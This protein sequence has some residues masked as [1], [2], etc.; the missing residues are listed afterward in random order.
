MINA[1]EDKR[2]THKRLS[3]KDLAS[4]LG[5]PP[6]FWSKLTTTELCNPHEFRKIA[7]VGEGLCM[8]F[9]ID[10]NRVNISNV[11]SVIEY[12]RELRGNT[13]KT[14]CESAGIDKWAYIRIIRG[15]EKVLLSTIMKL[16]DSL[17]VKFELKDYPKW[18][19]T[20]FFHTHYLEELNA[21]AE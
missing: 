14:L 16:C 3:K 2:K 5:F 9:Y 7:T 13:K 18:L 6:A 21:K 19:G 8:G 20:N 17:A 11:G 12:Y 10:N 4:A 1:L 15:S